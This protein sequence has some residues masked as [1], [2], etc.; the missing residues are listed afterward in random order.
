VQQSKIKKKIIGG[1][2]KPAMKMMGRGRRIG[3][4][5]QLEKGQKLP[6]DGLKTV[7]LAHPRAVRQWI[8]KNKTL[9]PSRID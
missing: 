5:K 6:S 9:I 7:T 1:L 3:Q 2:S 8:I 4:L